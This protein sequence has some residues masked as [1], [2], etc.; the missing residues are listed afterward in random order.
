MLTCV[1]IQIV[2]YADA[3]E[4]KTHTTSLLR[5]A[6]IFRIDIRKLDDSFGDS[7]LVVLPNDDMKTACEILN[8]IHSYGYFHSIVHRLE[9]NYT[10]QDLKQ[11]Q[12]VDCKNVS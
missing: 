5:F 10:E 9:Y 3:K 7:F 4:L 6:G 12:K 1:K 2:D 11:F 8:V